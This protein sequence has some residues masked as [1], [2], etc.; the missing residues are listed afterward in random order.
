M[1]AN[2]QTY[3]HR[4]SPLVN[5]QAPALEPEPYFLPPSPQVTQVIRAEELQFRSE[6]QRRLLRQ[7]KHLEQLA[8]YLIHVKESAPLRKSLQLHFIR[9]KQRLEDFIG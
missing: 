5:H 4:W 6:P 3:Y 7:I 8:D 9:L 2:I 1:E